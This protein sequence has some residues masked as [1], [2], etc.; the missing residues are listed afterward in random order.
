[1]TAVTTNY[2]IYYKTLNEITT[3]DRRVLNGLTLRP[4]SG[5]R[6]DVLSKKDNLD[7]YHIF[8]AKQQGLVI[9][10]AVLFPE[11]LVDCFYKNSE[12]YCCYVYVRYSARRKGVGTRLLKKVTKLAKSKGNVKVFP[13]DDR[14]DKFFEARNTNVEI[15][16]E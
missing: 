1:M 7:S 12:D 11:N 15:V 13:W 8:M 10:W 16:Y 6:D 5:M 9:G 4:A 2:R 14:S 3:K